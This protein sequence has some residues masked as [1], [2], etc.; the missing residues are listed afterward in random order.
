MA[1]LRLAVD[2][3]ALE[4][5][6]FYFLGVLAFEVFHARVVVDIDG[7]VLDGEVNGTAVAH[8]QGA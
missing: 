6:P 1:M 7:I 4:C 2:A 3:N 8:S 5:V